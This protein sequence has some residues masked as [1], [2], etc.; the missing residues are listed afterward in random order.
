MKTTAVCGP[1]S[2]RATPSLREA[3]KRQRTTEPA[4]DPPI[5]RRTLSERSR[6]PLPK[7]V[8]VYEAIRN[9]GLTKD[10]YEFSRKWLGQSDN[11]F[12]VLKARSKPFSTAALVR[13][14]FRLDTLIESYQELQGDGILPLIL[15]LRRIHLLQL[16][17][18][19]DCELIRIS[20]PL[21]PVK[22]IPSLDAEHGR[23]A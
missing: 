7:P 17:A 4:G 1:R 20:A 8:E 5:R 19:V 21:R 3:R 12:S 9:L 22:Q 23:S 15:Q 16:S 2:G 10:Q 11:Y 6:P 14:K 13:L 18:Q